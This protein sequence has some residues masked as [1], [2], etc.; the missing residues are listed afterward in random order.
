MEILFQDDNIQVSKDSS[1]E[2]F[3]ENL[4]S[5]VRVRVSNTQL[6]LKLTCVGSKFQIVGSDIPTIEVVK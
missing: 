2:V 1:D 3:V 6:T 5:G 4:K